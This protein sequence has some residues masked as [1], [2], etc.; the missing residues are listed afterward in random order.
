MKLA[1]GGLEKMELLCNLFSDTFFTWKMR[2]YKLLG[3]VWLLSLY[4]KVAQPYQLS[5]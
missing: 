5:C 3:L 1:P 4:H 2:S